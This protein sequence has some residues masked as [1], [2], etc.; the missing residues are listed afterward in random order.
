MWAQLQ[1]TAG[2]ARKAT[3]ERTQQMLEAKVRAEESAD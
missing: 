3:Q 1:A 2:A